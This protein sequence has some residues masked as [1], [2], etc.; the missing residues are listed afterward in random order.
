[1]YRKVLGMDSYKKLVVWQENRRLNREIYR[2]VS[3]FPPSELYALSDQLKRASISITSNI[4]EGYGQGSL[5]NRLRFLFMARGSQYEVE[6]QLTIACD[7]G[8]ATEADIQTAIAIETKIGK[9]LSGLI[10]YTID[11]IHRGESIRIEETG[12]EYGTDSEMI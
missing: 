11:Q 3:K 2:V 6:T 8:F 4:A 7:L 9:L 10:R 5:K 1:M 12:Y